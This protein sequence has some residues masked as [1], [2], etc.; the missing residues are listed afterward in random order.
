MRKSD[1]IYFS[2]LKEEVIEKFLNDNPVYEK[3]SNIWT[4][5]EIEMFREDFI[6]KVHSGFSEKWFY[7]YFKNPVEKIPRIDMLNLLS[8]YAGYA[9]YS[10][11]MQKHKTEELSARPIADR[12]RSFEF[13]L[14]ILVLPFIVLL[15]YLGYTFSQDDEHAYQFC[16]VESDN[17]QI[18]RTPLQVTILLKNESPVQLSTDKN[19]CFSYTSQS[20]DIQFIVESPFYKKDTIFRST[21]V[22]DSETINL[23]SNDYALLLKYYTHKD[24]KD[25]KEK[26]YRLN[27]MID[28]NAIIYRLYPQQGIALYSKSQFVNELTLP[29]KKVKNV[30]IVSTKYQDG[31]LS[32]IKFKIGE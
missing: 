30:Q 5:K 11:F 14:W 9:N 27:Q 17:G 21:K 22:G 7:T 28:D 25:W 20:D 8:Q 26:R 32:E 3:N 4:G 18:P 16:F 23:K 2:L 19:G 12:A 10:E 31:K 13:R 6:Q 15:A 1:I 24:V 29:T